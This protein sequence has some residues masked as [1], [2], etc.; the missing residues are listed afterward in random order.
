[1]R[2]LFHSQDSGR[3]WVAVSV[4]L[5]VML[6]HRSPGGGGCCDRCAIGMTVEA[7]VEEGV[8]DGGAI[9][10]EFGAFQRETVSATAVCVIRA[11]NTTVAVLAPWHRCCCCCCG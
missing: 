1:M 10:G 6:I 9:V 8:V 5:T 7:A 2:G 3:R 4:M 11:L